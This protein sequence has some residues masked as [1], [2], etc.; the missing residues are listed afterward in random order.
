[1]GCQKSRDGT[2]GEKT[3]GLMRNRHE[4]PDGGQAKNGTY[5]A[6]RGPGEGEG[7]EFNANTMSL[8]RGK[9]TVYG[10]VQ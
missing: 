6:G 7:T 9:K 8:G 3:A 5:I 4:E 1:M 2:G 10:K